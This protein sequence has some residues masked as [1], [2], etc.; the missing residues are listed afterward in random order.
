M[1]IHPRYWIVTEAKCTFDI[2]VIRVE[3]KYDL[4]I[5]AAIDSLLKIAIAT[6]KAEKLADRVV[7]GL[8]GPGKEILRALEELERKHELTLAETI[9]VLLSPVTSFNAA[10]IR[11][12]RHPDNPDRKADEA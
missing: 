11:I 3:E 2:A 7:E 8:D 5:E 4:S 9:R 1:Q 6:N 10:S 12:D